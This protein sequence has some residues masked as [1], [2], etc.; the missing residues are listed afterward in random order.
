MK[1]LQELRFLAELRRSGNLTFACAFAGV[2]R[3]AALAHRKAEPKF[4]KRWRAAAADAFVEFRRL[5]EMP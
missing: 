4:E 3:K 1:A 5:R 2:T